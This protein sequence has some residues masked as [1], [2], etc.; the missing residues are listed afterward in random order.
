MKWLFTD[1]PNWSSIKFYM[2]NLNWFS[3]LYTI[4]YHFISFDFNGVFPTFSW[5]I[6]GF[7]LYSKHMINDFKTCLLEYMREGTRNVYRAVTL[8]SQIKQNNYFVYSDRIISSA[9]QCILPL[10]PPAFTEELMLS[11]TICS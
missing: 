2:V 10:S 9:N 1:V 5:I 4:L 11:C 6:R 3:F 7:F 8:W